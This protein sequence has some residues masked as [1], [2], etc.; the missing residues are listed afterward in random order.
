M[1][2]SREAALKNLKPLDFVREQGAEP[3]KSG[4]YTLVRE[5]F[6]WVRN[7]AL[8][9]KIKVLKVVEEGPFYKL[10]INLPGVLAITPGGHI[11]PRNLMGF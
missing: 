10:P 11:G 9:Q 2:L 3:L 5:H 8:G 4:A 6:E 7:T 1:F